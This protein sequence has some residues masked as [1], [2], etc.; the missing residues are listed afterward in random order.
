[1]TTSPRRPAR[2]ALVALVPVT[3]CGCPSDAPPAAGPAP[4]APRDPAATGPL[5]VYSGRGEGLVG[6]LLKRFEQERGVALSIRYGGTPELASQL[7]SEGASSPADVIF[8]QDSGYLG[9]LARLGLLE[10]LPATLL[11]RVDPRFRDPEGR[12]LGT[13]ARA[14]VLVYATGA[15]RPDELPDAL[16]DLAHPRWKGKL[17]WAPGNAS[18]QAHVSYLRHAWG[19]ERTRAWLV[20]VQAN[21]PTV[22]AKNGQIVEGV[23][24]GD[25]QV[26]W[27]NHYYLHRREEGAPAANYSFRAPKDAGNVLM[28]SGVAVRAG[29]PRA[30]Q[31]RELIEFL[32]GE[33]AQRHFA[34]ETFEYPAVPGVPTHPR[35]P[36]LDALG[37][38]DVDQAH[39]ADVGPTLKLLQ[40]LGLQ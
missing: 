26:G 21:E 28:V 36:A 3:L 19:E 22:Y 24:T 11:E 15:I 1:M 38:A 31:A 5:V 20:A 2:A 17:G 14:R 29:S 33:A 8:A 12:W 39:L 30:A 27:V 9:A 37:L 32:A 7:A 23:L 35:V 18:F 6:P 40:E 13:S 16:A 4:V 34:Q 10:A 25:V